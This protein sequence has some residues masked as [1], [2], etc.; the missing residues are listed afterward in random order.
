LK[1][2]FTFGGSLATTALG[3]LLDHAGTQYRSD[4]TSSLTEGR[5]TI[6]DFSL[7]H[8]HGLFQLDGLLAQQA[9]TLAYADAAYWTAIATLLFLPLVPFL[10]AMRKG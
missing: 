2:S 5:A 4:L 8:P 9:Q 1:L 10:P 7:S 3:I 6:R